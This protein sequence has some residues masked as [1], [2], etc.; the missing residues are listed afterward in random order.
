M[1]AMI[2]GLAEQQQA[3]PASRAARQ[4]MT[5]ASGCCWRACPDGGSAGSA[6]R[7]V[8]LGCRKFTAMLS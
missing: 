5:E 1:I 7:P 4:S 2:A 3:R 8:T 6:S